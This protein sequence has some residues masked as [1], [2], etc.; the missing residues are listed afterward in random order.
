MIA[1]KNSRRAALTPR[2]KAQAIDTAL[3]VL[4]LAAIPD[5]PQEGGTEGHVAIV[6][7]D[8]AGKVDWLRQEEWA[9]FRGTNQTHPFTQF[10]LDAVIKVDVR[11]DRHGEER[12]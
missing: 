3:L 12:T 5:K 6:P 2:Q 9:G 4:P 10:V 1:G 7:V 8:P 11:E